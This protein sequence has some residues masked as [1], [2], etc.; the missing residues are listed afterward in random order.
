MLVDLIAEETKERGWS[1]IEKAV[2]TA[3]HTLQI[4]KDERE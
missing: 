1:K 2:I 4:V 3:R